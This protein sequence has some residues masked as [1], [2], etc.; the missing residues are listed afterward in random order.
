M[1]T[2]SDA[3]KLALLAFGESAAAGFADWGA[4]ANSNFSF[5]E[6][7]LVEQSSITVTGANV[8]LSDE[9]F[10]SVLLKFNGALTGNHNIIVPAR[11][12]F[13]FVRNN[14]S[15][16]FTLNVKVSGQPGIVVAQKGIDI[17]YCDGTDVLSVLVGSTHR[18]L[19]S[20][21]LPSTAPSGSYYIWC[22]NSA[23]QFGYGRI[24][25]GT[26]AAFTAIT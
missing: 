20:S 1:A 18:V 4:A 24:S 9:Q 21:D 13:W 22:V 12:G 14:T 8:T 25:S 2:I 7:A 19:R 17:L 10:R 16:N 6:D 26:V 3:L 15:G 5:L 23:G 11:K